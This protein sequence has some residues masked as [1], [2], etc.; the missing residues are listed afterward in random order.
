MGLFQGIIVGLKEIWAHRLR[1]FLTMLGVVL[2]VAALASTFAFVEGMFSGWQ[3]SIED[4]GGIEKLWAEEEPVPE[5]Q[6]PYRHIARKRRMEDLWAVQ[7]NVPEIKTFS[8]EVM[9]WGTV[10]HYHNKHVWCRTQGVTE[11]TLS[12]NNY[13]VETGRF[14]SDVDRL[15]RAR[16]AVLGSAIAIELYGSGAPV[17]GRRAVI[18]T[19]PFRV[20]GVLKSRA[21]AGRSGHW[22]DWRDR[23]I[24]IPL[25]T[26]LDRFTGN[27]DLQ[28]LNFEVSDAS[29]VT[30]AAELI[31]N[32]LFFSHRRIACFSV[33]TNEEMVERFLTMSTAFNITMSLIAGISLVVGGI[34]I[35]NIMLAS[36][37]E[38]IR[39]IGIRKAIGARDR[40]VLTQVM[41]EAVTLSLLGGLLG[42]VVSLA[43]T[44]AI[45]EILQGTWF[46]GSVVKA[47]PLMLA[48]CVSVLVGIVFGLYPALKAARLDPIE[49]LRY[50]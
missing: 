35:M 3:Q 31:Q 42:I 50:E 34:G 44:Q 46:G 27:E 47:G 24:F 8:P 17:L 18:N 41:I 12:V 9:V 15:T 45:E 4:D 40:D 1:S 10:V 14:I 22:H 37:N 5:D 23:I 11:G 7:A 20:I 13:A 33:R 19:M 16:V 29:Q 38:R 36:I 25:E 6:Q 2:G 32:V 30:S 21:R 49:A 43:L 28:G 48:F 39:Q 26:C